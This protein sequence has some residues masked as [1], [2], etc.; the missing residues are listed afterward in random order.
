MTTR[1]LIDSS[2]QPKYKQLIQGI[3]DAIQNGDLKQGD[4]LPSLNAVKMRYQLSRD[5]VLMAFN[6]LKSRGII[7]SIVG[8]GYYVKSENIDVKKRVFVLFDELNA[9][10]EDLYN[11]LKGSLGADTQV[12]IFFHHFNYRVF[13]DLILDNQNSYNYYVIMPANLDNTSAIIDRLP[14]DKV[15]ILD[16]CHE[17]HEHFAAVYQNFKKD[18]ETGLQQA[19]VHTNKYKEWILLFDETRQPKGIKEGFESYCSQRN[20]NYS[21][22]SKFEGILQISGLYIVLD[23]RDLIAILKS[24][25]EQQINIGEDVGVI[26]YNDTPLKEIV[27]GGITTISTDFSVMGERLAHMILTKKREQVENPSRLILRQSL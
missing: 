9:F 18:V 26:S 17:E 10:K 3:E 8:K 23:D 1:K 14:S 4:K 25:I 24:G 21:I 16:Q 27:N 12:D 22:Q 13:K 19:E 5:T 2:A 7:E 11:A 15:F 20:L 6:H